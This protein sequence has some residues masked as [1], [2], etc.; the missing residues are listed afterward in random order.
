MRADATTPG[1]HTGVLSFHSN[2]VTDKNQVLQLFLYVKCVVN[3]HAHCI[4][5]LLF[6]S[7]VTRLIA[8]SI[9][10]ERLLATDPEILR[11]LDV[12]NVSTFVCLFFGT[13]VQNSTY[14][15]SK[16]F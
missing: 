1:S 3:T 6:I 11:D 10:D 15:F 9:M 16:L 12:V 5:I 7:Q 8:I 14:L 13:S 4:L 2:Y